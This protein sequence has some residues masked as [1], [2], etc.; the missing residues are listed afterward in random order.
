MSKDSSPA[1]GPRAEAVVR[2]IDGHRYPVRRAA[3]RSPHSR[4]GSNLATENHGFESQ[5]LDAVRRYLDW[6]WFLVPLHAVFDQFRCTCGRE[7]CQSVGKHPLVRNGIYDARRDPGALAWWE[8]W[9]WANI[10]VNVGASGLSVLDIDPRNDGDASLAALLA[11]N[12]ELPPTLVA[13]TG[14][15]GRHFVF[16]ESTRS[17][18]SAKIAK[19]VDFLATGSLFVAEPSFH[20]SGS[21]YEW[22]NVDEVLAPVPEWLRHWADDSEGSR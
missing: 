13:R 10:G 12:G 21:R 20:K 15:G 7:D 3:P 6:G 11:E 16:E 2:T 9:P 4:L 17:L 5:I 18:R 22:W 19:G 1:R 8:W 14:G